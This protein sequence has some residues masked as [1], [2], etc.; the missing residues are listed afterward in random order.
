MTKQ[1]AQARADPQLLQNFLPAVGIAQKR[2]GDDVRK[3]FGAVHLGELFIQPLRHAVALLAEFGADLQQFRHQQRGFGFLRRLGGQFADL[4]DR[5][6]F[7]LRETGERDPRKSLQD[8]V[9]GAILA[10]HAGAHQAEARDV[11]KIIDR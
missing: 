3:H 4:G 10:L 2:M 6:R 7:R 9:G 1:E 8:Q 5:K 11:V